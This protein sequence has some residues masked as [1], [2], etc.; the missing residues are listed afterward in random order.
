MACAVK[1]NLSPV[2]RPDLDV[3]CETLVVQLG[4]TSP[5]FLAVCYRAPDADQETEKIA[6][7]LRNLHRTGRPFLMVGEEAEEEEEEEEPRASV[8][9]G[10]AVAEGSH[11][12]NTHT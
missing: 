7:L 9:E 6:G 2:H 5:A 3:D 11:C 12:G 8:A 1:S 4:A 10:P